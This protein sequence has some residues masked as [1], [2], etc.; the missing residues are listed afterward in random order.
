MMLRGAP[1]N[2]RSGTI[3]PETDGINTSGPCSPTRTARPAD[4]DSSSDAP[5]TPQLALGAV[6]SAGPQLIGTAV[7]GVRGSG[8]GS[9]SAAAAPSAA[10]ARHSKSRDMIKRMVKKLSAA[11]A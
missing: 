9:G 1:A 6:Q 5:A 11:L 8:D 7:M 2:C 10:S 4:T 3:E